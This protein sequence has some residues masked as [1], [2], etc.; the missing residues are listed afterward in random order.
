M[1]LKAALNDHTVWDQF[2]KEL[3]KVESE[4]MHTLKNSPESH[5]MYR[6]QGG[7]EALRKVKRIKEV[8]NA[9]K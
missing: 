3:E 6:S 1:S 5:I 8:L 7:L 9:R 4:F 2:L